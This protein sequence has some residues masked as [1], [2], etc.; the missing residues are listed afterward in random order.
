MACHVLS[1]PPD[2]SSLLPER[3]RPAISDEDERSVRAALLARARS[4]LGLELPEILVLHGAPYAEILHC[5]ERV[6][7]SYIVVGSHGRTGLA[8]AL[9]G[10]VAERVVRHAHCSVLVARA[11]ARSEPSGVVVAATDL[12]DASLPVI[13]EGHAAA[14][15]SGARLVVMTVIDWGIDLGSAVSGLVGV[16]PALP[17]PELRQQVHE[18]L[19]AALVQAMAGVGAEG[20]ARVLDGSPAAQIVTQSE[21]SGADLLVVGTR[22]RTGLARLALGNVAERVVGATKCSVLAVRVPG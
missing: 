8:H 16:L 9:L 17:P 6:R 1:A 10:S 12:S 2:L 14:K 5:A 11:G 22:G 3:F 15:R 19:R 4:E 20:E 18:A 7:A 13:V 21:S